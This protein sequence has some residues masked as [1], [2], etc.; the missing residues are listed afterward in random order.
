[1]NTSQLQN[2]ISIAQTLNYSETAKSAYISQPALT[3]QINKLESELGVKLFER[4]RH[5]VS[6]TYAGE[7]FYKFAVDILDGVR[8]AENRMNSISAGQ[9]GFL[10]ISSVYSMETLISEAMAR[11]H[12]RYPE[13]L[14]NLLAGTGTSQIMTIRK[15]SY[16]VF[17]SFSNLLDSFP[18]ICTLP[19]ASDRFALYIHKKYKEEYDA[20]GIQLLNR[21][22]HFVESSSEGPF[23]TNR[24]FAI[25][26]ALGIGREHI[27]YYPSSTTMLTAVQAGLGFSLLPLGMN[28]GMLP[29][30]VLAIP[31]DIPE[32]LI[33]RSVGWHKNNRNIA[34]KNFV[35]MMKER[36]A[37]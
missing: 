14:L 10:K 11:Y 32:A 30:N 35:E 24:T 2:F 18:E 4:S 31:L 19:V 25:M 9:T 17:F 1:M 15:M 8:Q 33:E 26:D 16:D 29:E 20:Y 7:E 27:V 37:E 6:L 36:S 3:K 22:L 23:L 13:I 21:L 34:L 12:A 28:H 5:G